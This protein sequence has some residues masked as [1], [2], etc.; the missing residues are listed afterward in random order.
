M[1]TKKGKVLGQLV[2][3][4]R[5]LGEPAKDYVLLAEGNTSAKIDAD[6][7]YVKASGAALAA[8]TEDGFVEMSL[9]RVLKMLDSDSLT[10]QAI[11]ERLMAA[12]VDGSAQARP[13]VETTFHASLLSLEGVSF[14][15]HTHPAAVNAIL[16]SKQGKEIVRGRIF[17]DE[18]VYTGREPLWIDYADPGLALAKSILR[19]V[20]D[21][22]DRHGS[23]PKVLLLQNHGLIAI[24]SK[25]QEVEYITAMWVKTARVL[26][27]TQAF[28]GP[29]YL[30]EEQVR[31]LDARDDI[32]YRRRV[33]FGR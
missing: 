29:S 23:L 15:G 16:C 33:V 11:R 20:R 27:G 25:P 7:F 19:G 2:S 28:G 24:G 6:R 22:L 4:S 3:M 13:S 30:S 32:E 1:A 17:P 31:R 21:Y 9:P 18:V 8:I 12:R 10:E 14:V 5:N 26:A